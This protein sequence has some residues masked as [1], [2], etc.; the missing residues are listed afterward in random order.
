[1]KVI[2]HQAVGMDVPAGLH[3]GFSQRLEPLLPILIITKDVLP[4]VP[5]VHNVVDRSW[6][7]NA[8]FSGHEGR[9]KRIR[10]DV[11]MPICGT[12]PSMTPRRAIISKPRHFSP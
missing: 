5:S 9:L 3:T 7:L 11:N 8:Q 1:M 6:I 2:A 12:D 4:P 10:I